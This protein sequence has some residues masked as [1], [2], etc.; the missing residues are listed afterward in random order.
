MIL[1]DKGFS[2]STGYTLTNTWDFAIVS[3]ESAIVQAAQN[4]LLATIGSWIFDDDYWSLM[5]ELKN[6]PIQLITDTQIQWYIQIALQPMIDASM[7]LSIASVIITDRWTDS[8]QVE[9]K[10][11]LDLSIGILNINFVI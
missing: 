7:I 8:L 6:T 4:R 3:D 10:L 9:I 5:T 11:E 2:G 1:I